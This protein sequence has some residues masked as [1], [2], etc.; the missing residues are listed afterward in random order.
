MPEATDHT[1]EPDPPEADTRASYEEFSN[2]LGSDVVVI[3]GLDRGGGSGG[4]GVHTNCA[5]HIG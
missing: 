5:P 2:A 3:L 4:G 1:Y